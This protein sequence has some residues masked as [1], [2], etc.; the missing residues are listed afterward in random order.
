MLMSD[1]LNF[2]CYIHDAVVDFPDSAR[3]Q[4]FITTI[5]ENDDRFNVH[6]TREIIVQIYSTGEL[7]IGYLNDDLQIPPSE[8]PEPMQAMS[9]K[10]YYAYVLFN[11][12]WFYFC[13]IL[14]A[15]DG[16]SVSIPQPYNDGRSVGFE[17]I[18]SGLDMDVVCY[19]N[20]KDDFT[21]L[22]RI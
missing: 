21:I 1:S 6:N 16:S 13:Y 5:A 8:L 3:F 9:G 15:E 7:T 10:G 18:W 4:E 19:L 12:G 11:D 22:N 14:V 17:P 20:L 2:R